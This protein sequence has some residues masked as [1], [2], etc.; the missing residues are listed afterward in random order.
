MFA[1]QDGRG[2]RCW[3]WGRQVARGRSW[4][5]PSGSSYNV[6]YPNCGASKR[7][8][9]VK[10]ESCGVALATNYKYDYDEPITI[11]ALQY[12]QF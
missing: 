3:C 5:R 7:K 9:K 10:G 2:G 8:K 1:M 6:A 4:R 11:T 12:L